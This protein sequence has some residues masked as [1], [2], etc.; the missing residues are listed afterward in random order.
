MRCRELCNAE[1]E[2]QELVQKLLRSN[3]GLDMGGW[4]DLLGGVVRQELARLEAGG[5]GA[6]ER[7]MAMFNLQRCGE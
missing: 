1:E 5:L 2:F 3:A 4:V 7:G 6:W